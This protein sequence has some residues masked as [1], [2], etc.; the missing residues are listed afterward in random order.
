VNSALV[1]IL[2]ARGAALFA[3]IFGAEMLGAS[4]TTGNSYSTGLDL[5]WADAP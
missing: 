5:I 4:D 1:R 2:A 3:A